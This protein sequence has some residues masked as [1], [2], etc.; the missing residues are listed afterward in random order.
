MY[1]I[2][3]FE[4]EY[5]REVDKYAS[6]RIG[7]AEERSD[8]RKSSRLSERSGRVWGET[9][10]GRRVGGGGPD[11]GVAASAIGRF[12][13]GGVKGVARGRSTLRKRSIQIT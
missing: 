7:I 10:S 11:G 9:K 12:R 3:R 13:C 5:I 6:C 2:Q 8:N 4:V 1:V